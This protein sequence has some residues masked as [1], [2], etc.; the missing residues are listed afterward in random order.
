MIEFKFDSRDFERSLK[1]YPED[2]TKELRRASKRSASVV[3]EYAKQNHR[4]TTRTGTLVKSI[5]A[6]GGVGVDVVSRK[7]FFGKVGDALFGKNKKANGYV[8][9]VLHDE[10]QPLGTKYGKYVHQGHGSWGA[11]RFIDNAVNKHVRMIHAAW[12]RA[13]DNANKRF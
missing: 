6:Y 5:K 10:G 12:N 9:L 1:K 4:F 8:N 2:L 7:G 3:E 11:D 13:F